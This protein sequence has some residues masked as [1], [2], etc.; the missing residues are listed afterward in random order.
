VVDFE[1]DV[2]Y[3]IDH[4]I[5][6]IDGSGY[7]LYM[8]ETLTTERDATLNLQ[9]VFN[10]SSVSQALLSNGYT[11]DIGKTQINGAG[12][13]GM[14]VVADG[15]KLIISFFYD[16]MKYGYKVICAVFF[17]AILTTRSLSVA[18]F[19]T[20]RSPTLTAC[21]NTTSGLAL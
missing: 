21:V 16:R 19:Q 1:N 7:E 20:T 6:S 12:A 2:L 10:G 15:N 11:N 8:N 4:C 14:T 13:T 3:E 17:R 18:P 9:E 5:Q